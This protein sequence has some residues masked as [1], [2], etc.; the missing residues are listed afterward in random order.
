MSPQDN[1]HY[2]W[3][4]NVQCV[5]VHV[6]RRRLQLRGGWWGGG[7]EC[8]YTYISVYVC[9]LMCVL[10]HGPTPRHLLFCRVL[11]C[12]PP[13]SPLCFHT[14][15]NHATAAP[16][17]GSCACM[18]AGPNGRN[19]KVEFCLYLHLFK[20]FLVDSCTLQRDCKDHGAAR[21][22]RGSYS[23]D[24]LRIH[25]PLYHAKKQSLHK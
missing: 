18:H 7:G 15:L 17:V 8:A 9:V 23:V 13:T 1:R 6:W 22:L 11:W 14:S 10:E 2:F 21:H 16:F 19:F 3:W 24:P 20:E 5:C 12:H 4:G 25:L